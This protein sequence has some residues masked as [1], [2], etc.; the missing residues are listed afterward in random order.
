MTFYYMYIEHS[1]S[2][3]D[4]ICMAPMGIVRLACFIRLTE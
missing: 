1:A 4:R 2:N 3:D